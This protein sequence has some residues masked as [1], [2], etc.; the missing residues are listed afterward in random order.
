MGSLDRID[1]WTG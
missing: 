1:L